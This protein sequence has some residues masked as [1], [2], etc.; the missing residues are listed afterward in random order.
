MTAK[1]L[2]KLAEDEALKKASRNMKNAWYTA[3]KSQETIR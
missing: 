2:K 1:T 3:P